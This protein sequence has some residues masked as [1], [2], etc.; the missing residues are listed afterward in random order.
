MNSI[1][2][3]VRGGGNELLT[4]Y[5]LGISIDYTL[6]HSTQKASLNTATIT[7]SILQ[8]SQINAKVKVAVIISVNRLKTFLSGPIGTLMRI[9][10]AVIKGV[11]MRMIE[12]SSISIN[13][14]R[15]SN[16]KLLIR[17]LTSNGLAQ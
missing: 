5:S 4:F 2:S 1:L 13:S 10:L 17:S 16:R 9:A 11:S 8:N 7:S 12:R 3:F 15:P 14:N 6:I